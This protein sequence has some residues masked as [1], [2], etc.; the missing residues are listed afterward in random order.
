MILWINS[1]NN[2]LILFPTERNPLIMKSILLFWS[3]VLGVKILL[4]TAS[5]YQS[6][7]AVEE[8]VPSSYT[9]ADS[10]KQMTFEQQFIRDPKTQE[11]QLSR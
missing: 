5:Y 6:Q 9:T 3:C 8:R 4:S 7:Q 11:A 10:T 1:T 2:Q